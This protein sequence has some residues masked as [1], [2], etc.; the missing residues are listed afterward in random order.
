MDAGEAEG[1]GHVAEV[2]KLAA[3]EAATE[4]VC[5]G[6]LAADAR[7]VA[8]CRGALRLSLAVS[9]GARAA[10]GGKAQAQQLPW[11]ARPWSR[12]ENQMMSTGCAAP[13]LHQHRGDIPRR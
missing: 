13:L 1:A 5:E 9:R 4:R 6:E 10:R 7:G 2:G 11:P 12:R 3:L 8:A